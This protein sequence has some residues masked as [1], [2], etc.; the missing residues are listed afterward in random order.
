MANFEPKEF[1]DGNLKEYVY[2]YIREFEPDITE[3]NLNGK[4]ILHFHL[5]YFGCKCNYF[6]L[7]SINVCIYRKSPYIC[8]ALHHI[9]AE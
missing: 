3:E 6:K 7:F 5:V 8:S 4:V 2:G 1:N 9:R